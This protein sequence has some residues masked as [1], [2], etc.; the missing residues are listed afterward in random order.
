MAPS[1]RHAV[2]LSQR[3]PVTDI[4]NNDDMPRPPG[5]PKN[6][7]KPGQRIRWWRE[8][9]GFKN[10]TKFANELGIKSSTLSDFESGRSD[11][12][13]FIHILIAALG[14]NT[15]YVNT[16][17]GEPEAEFPQEPPANDMWP[18]DSISPNRLKKLNRIERAYVEGKLHEALDEIESERRKTRREHDR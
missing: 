2:D 9:R 17:E 13:K 8:Y 5:M 6:L 12:S 16:G 18:L 11:G 15:H 10:R 4:R 7:Q 3:R 1:L 14:L